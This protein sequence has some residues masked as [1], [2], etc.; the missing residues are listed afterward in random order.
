MFVEEIR[1]AIEASPRCQLPEVAAL[2]W[3]AF[4]AGQVTE[5]EAEALSASIDTRRA[6]PAVAPIK[7]SGTR[8]RSSSS[9]ER[10]RRWAASGTLPPRLAARFTL[11]EQAVLAVIGGEIVKQ[12]RCTLFVGHIAALAGVSETSVRNTLRQ[13]RGLGLIAVEIRRV[14]AWRN[15]SNVVT[16]VSSEWSAWLNRGGLRGG[17]KSALGTIS[18]IKLGSTR[19]ASHEEEGYRKGGGRQVRP[20]SVW[21]LKWPRMAVQAVR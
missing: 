10:R 13:A 12:G 21:P 20:R 16:I 18:S 9:I 11:A 7:R 8:P 19:A 3:R 1:R 6:L 15:D 17:C 4:G 2:L 14:T 5:A